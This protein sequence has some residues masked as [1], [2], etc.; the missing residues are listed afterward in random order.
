MLKGGPMAAHGLRFTLADDD[1]NFLFLMHHLLSRGFPGC[2]IASF[3]NAED[4]LH[5]VEN[6]GT[7][8]IVTDHTMGSMTGAKLIQELRR[9][10]SSVP[11]IMVSG[12]SNSEREALTAGATEFLHKDLVLEHLVERVR[13]HLLL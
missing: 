10:N 11:I 12:D 5:H 3:S 2:S 6:S 9:K 4:A 8:L 13:K 1:G 7:D